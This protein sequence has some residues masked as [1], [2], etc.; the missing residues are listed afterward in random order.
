MLCVHVPYRG[1]APVRESIDQLVCRNCAYGEIQK[2]GCASIMYRDHGDF[3]P[4][5]LIET[6]TPVNF[7]NLLG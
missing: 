4:I 1:R 7:L 2:I 6:Q 3:F 5:L